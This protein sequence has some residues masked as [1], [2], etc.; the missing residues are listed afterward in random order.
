M[1]G[2][3]TVLCP[4]FQEPLFVSK[5]IAIDLYSVEDVCAYIRR[6]LDILHGSFSWKYG[7]SPKL[8]YIDVISASIWLSGDS[9]SKI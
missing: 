5:K 3:Y 6:G 4:R 2:S 9:G 7:Q 1:G 8:H